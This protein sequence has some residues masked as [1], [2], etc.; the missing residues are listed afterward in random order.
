V[1]V[2]VRATPG[3][4]GARV[5]IAVCDTGVGIAADKLATIFEPFV[6]VTQGLTRPH[7]GTGLGLSISRELARGM[8]GDLRV[9]S[10]PG[11]GSTFTLVLPAAA[12]AADATHPAPQTAASA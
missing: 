6:Q 8:G 10:A 7:E 5:S 1:S 9:T 4:A 2:Q 12:T 11:A 3:A